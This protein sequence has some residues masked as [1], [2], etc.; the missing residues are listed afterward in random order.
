MFKIM[1]SSRLLSL[2][3]L[4]I[5]AIAFHLVSVNGMF[6]DNMYIGW[7][8]HHSWM[9][10]NDLQLVLDQSSGS[11]VQSKGAFLFGSIQMQIK[12]VPGNSAG[13]VTAYYL[14]STGDKHDEIDFEFLGNVSGHPYIIHTN[15]FTQGAGGREQQFYPWFDPTADYHN[16]TIHW[17]PSAVV[18]YVDDIPIRVYKNYQSQGI[19]YPNAQGMG[20]YSSLWNADN[21]AT[22]GGLDKIDWTN[23][24]FIAK[25]RNFAPRA[26]P[27]Y[28]PGSI[29]HCAAPTPNNWYTSPEYS[30]LSYAKQGQMNWVRNNYMIYDYCKDTTRFNG[31]IPGECFKPQF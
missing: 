8:A 20:V 29:S 23:A 16:Y 14:S 1:A 3:N 28:G 12:L 5:L 18:W 22:R 15:I 24:P 6:S 21:W 27:W 30:Q 11:G 25:Y 7:G 26:C 2:A 9:Q 31:Q 4:F 17:N 13:T 10:G 19:L